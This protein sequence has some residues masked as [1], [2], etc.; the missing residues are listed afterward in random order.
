MRTFL[1]FQY[2]YIKKNWK[3]QQDGWVTEEIGGGGLS[4]ITLSEGI[5]EIHFNYN[6]FP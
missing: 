4:P 6:I 5:L 3:E 1:T 2:I